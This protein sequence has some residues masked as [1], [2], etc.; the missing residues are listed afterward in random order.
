MHDRAEREDDRV[1]LR[2]EPVPQPNPNRSIRRIR[3]NNSTLRKGKNR[4]PYTRPD[5]W[6]F[7]RALAI[8]KTKIINI[9]QNA[10]NYKKVK[11]RSSVD[12]PE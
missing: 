1:E 4:P 6:V 3:L 7:L 2:T 9:F 10:K 5:I 8:Q 11:L 12:F